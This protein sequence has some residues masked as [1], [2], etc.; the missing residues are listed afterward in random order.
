MAQALGAD[1]ELVFIEEAA[2]GTTPVSAVGYV[3]PV[4]AIAGD[5]FKRELLPNPTLRGNRNPSAPVRGN[6]T[7]SGSFT[8]PLGLEYIGWILK[9]CIGD[10]ASDGTVAPYTHVSKAGFNEAAVGAMELGLS[11]EIG[12]TVE[13]EYHLYTGCKLD[14][15]TVTG[16]SEGV[17]TFDVQVLGQDYAQS[18]SPQDSSPTS[19]TETPQDHFNMTMEEGGSSIATIKSCSLTFSNNHDTSQFVIGSAGQVGALPAGVCSV[20][21]SIEAI[22]SDDTLLTKAENHTESD[23]DLIWTSGSYSLT[24][25]VPEL[26]YSPASPAISGPAGVVT[27][28]SF[29]G[30]YANH[31]D[32]TCLKATLKNTT[33]DY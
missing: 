19:Y 28:L 30:Y 7:V 21:G 31:A 2:W 1:V 10:P 20:T 24:L 17:C 5:W 14:G 9:H 3:I 22:F 6:T 26:V 32:A 13:A 18:T 8:T 23:L 29:Q 25:Q 15:F 33:A 27:S 12:H 16:S 4:S 11:I